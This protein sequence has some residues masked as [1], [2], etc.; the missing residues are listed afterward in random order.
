MG[1]CLKRVP[2]DFDWPLKKIWQGYVNPYYVECSPC[3]GRGSNSEG[4][5]CK[6]CNGDGVPIAFQEK[7][8]EWLDEEPPEGDGFQLWE[9]TSEGSPISPVFDSLEKLCEWAER[10]AT[11]FGSSTATKEDWKQMLS[12]DFVYHKEGNHIFI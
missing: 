11:T 2:L 5:Y 10:N 7:Y 4:G 6:Y 1:R 3:D 8:N 9:T 12:D